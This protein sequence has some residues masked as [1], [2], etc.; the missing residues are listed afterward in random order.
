MTATSDRLPP[1][2]PEAEQ[3]ALGC[4]LIAPTLCLPECIKRLKVAAFYDLR[5]QTI[6]Q[7]LV[8]LHNQNLPADTI[9]LYQHLK[10]KNLDRE[11]GG[12][13]YLST[14]PDATPS[15]ANLDYYLDI[16]LDKYHRRKMVQTCTQ[17]VSR[18]YDDPSL[19]LDDLKFT[20]QSDLADVFGD[21]RNGLPDIIDLRDLLKKESPTPDLLIEGILHKG[22]KLSLGGGS[23]TFKSWTFLSMAVAITTGTPFLNLKT[24]KSKVLIINFEIAEVWM[25]H[26]LQ[27][28]CHAANLWPEPGTL[29][30]W[31]LR[32]YS[33]P[34]AILIPK[35][36]QRAKSLGYGLVI[37]DPSYKLI[38]QGDENSASD[39]AQMMASFERITVETASPPHPGA[40]VAFGAHFAK[41]NASAKESIDR[42]SG[43]GVFARDPDSI[44]TF[45]PHEEPNCFTVEATLRNLPQ[46]QPFVVEWQFPSFVRKEFLDPALLKKRPGRTRN[47]QRVQD[48]LQFLDQQSLPFS[49]WFKLA[50]DSIGINKSSFNNIRE[51]LELNGKI[52]QSKI[53]GN[54]TKINPQVQ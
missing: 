12:L 15:A 40:A 9:S 41:G 13:A 1:H 29:D 44:L 3:A 4:I 43:S 8:H 20:V 38:G 47:Q 39:V 37:I 22:S 32:G 52:F 48:V 31:N 45:T 25:R 30:L 7:T 35:I 34:H 16:L 51:Y 5:H 23:K 21:P 53:N 28:V 46:L 49:N 14:L 36:I 10:D 27:T 42:I 2:S 11:V 33:A 50:H 18:I 6:F 26:R 24:T 17:V 54:W 19:S